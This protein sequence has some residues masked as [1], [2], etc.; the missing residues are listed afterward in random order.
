MSYFKRIAVGLSGGID[1]AVSALLLKRKGLY[2]Q[3]SDD[4]LTMTWNTIILSRLRVIILPR[5][6][7]YRSSYEKLG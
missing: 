2:Y 1:S 7:C 3:N 4:L 6:R 5:V